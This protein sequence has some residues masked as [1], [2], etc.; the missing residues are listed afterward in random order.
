MG[1]E[2]IILIVVV[3]LVCLVVLLLGFIVKL[4]KQ[5]NNQTNNIYDKIKNYR[6]VDE[7]DK[8][9]IIFVID[10]YV[11][12]AHELKIHSEGQH[13]KI[14]EQLNKIKKKYFEK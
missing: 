6:H 11:E 8:E 3:V 4:I 12:Y 1:V 2:T 14:V 7:K 9:F 10:M 13:E 5:N